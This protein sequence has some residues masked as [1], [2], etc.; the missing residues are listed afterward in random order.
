MGFMA[1]HH[2]ELF[3]VV[4]PEALARLVEVRGSIDPAFAA[5]PAEVIRGQFDMVL[6]RIQSFLVT[7]DPESYR[8]FASR[9]MA[10]RV[11]A[12]EP[13]QN[14][15]HA[16]VAIGDVVVQVAQARLGQGDQ[17]T[18]FARAIGRMSFIGSRLLVEH[19]ADEL[20]QRK[21]HYRA[22]AGTSR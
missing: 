13:A 18:D 21:E 15:V 10:M 3:R 16:V 6:D 19:L 4:R 9:W 11:S 1:Q 5:I 20:E 17:L 2:A 7:E 12:G 8:A 14:L 22:L